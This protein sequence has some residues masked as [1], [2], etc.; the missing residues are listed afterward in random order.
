MLLSGLPRCPP[1][2]GRATPVR[3][4]L[5]GDTVVIFVDQRLPL[6]E[7]GVVVERSL[8]VLLDLELNADVLLRRCRRCNHEY[9]RARRHRRENPLPLGASSLFPL[10]QPNAPEPAARRRPYRSR[11]GL[12]TM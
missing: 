2:R 10:N 3:Q 9:Q 8:R 1:R 7:P 5:A 11:T 6:R 4:G 12:A